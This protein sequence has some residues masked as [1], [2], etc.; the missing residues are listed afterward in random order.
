[1]YQ[2]SSAHARIDRVIDSALTDNRL[3]G[4]VVLVARD[5]KTVYGRAAGLLDREA[6]TPM[7][8]DAIFRLA[9]VS[10]PLV[11]AAAMRLVERSVIELDQPVS[12]WLPAFRPALP[13]G[14]RP[15]ITLHQLLTHTSGLSY[16]FLE[17][18]DSTYHRLDVSDGLDQPGRA[19]EEN[20]RRLAQTSLVFMPGTSW[21]YSLG[22]DVIG[23]VL[24]AATGNPL[25][26]IVR[27]EVTGPLGLVDTGFTVTDRSRL[28]TP[29]ANVAEGRPVRMEGTITVPL[30]AQVGGGAIPFSPDRIFDPTSFL[31]GGAGMAGTAADV[32]ALLEAI[33]TGG[34]P[35]LKPETIAAMMRDHAG[36]QAEAQGPGWGFGYGGAVLVDPVPTGTPQAA[37]TFQW[38]GAYGH[39]WFVDPVHKLSVVA[40]TDTAFEGM[41]GQFV[42]D[43]RDAVYG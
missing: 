10:K 35:I 1:M 40:L 25:D 19:M 43:L 6:G 28:A 37:G 16:R 7:R 11:T 14:S 20:L 32:L 42:I 23:A 41:A 5:G 22:I 21:R 3:V 24:Q 4:A 18:E 15:E 26:E 8:A 34:S 39:C 31:S 27:D 2:P 38:G 17:P 30:P 13:D 36:P 29:Y 12:Q 9:S 33:R